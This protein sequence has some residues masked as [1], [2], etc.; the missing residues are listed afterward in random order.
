MGTVHVNPC[1]GLP[2]VLLAITASASAGGSTCIGDFDNNGIV[3]GADLG[4]LLSAWGTPAFDPSGDGNVD[5]TDLGIV[6]AAWGSCP[7]ALEWS[8]VTQLTSTSTI[9]L[10]P[11]GATVKTWT[12]GGQ[13]ASVAYLRPDGS[14]V[15]PCV[16]SAGSLNSA[17]RGGRIQIFS[18]AGTLQNDL[19]V[20]TSTSQQ[21]HDIRPMPNG[22]ILCVVWDVRSVAEQTAAGRINATASVWSEQILEL[23]PTGTN[24]YDI[25]WQWK[26]WDH[27][28]QD[29]A[30]GSANY[31]T[32]ASH[33]ELID[34][35]YSPAASPV[36][37]IHMNSIDY[38]A[39][40]DEIVVSSRSWSELWVI[41]HSTTTAQAASH[42]GGTRGRGGDL[43]Y[44]WGNPLASR[45]G[46]SADRNF[47]V[48]HSATWIPT[49][50]PGAGNIMVFNNG[51]R[52]G[53]TND[54]SQVVELAPPRDTSGGYVVPTTG[55]FGPAVPT[56]TV[57]S[58]GAFYGGPTQCGAFR[59]LSNTTLITL[60]SSDTLF[61]VDASGHTISTRTL[62]GSVAR[63]PRYRLVNGLWIGP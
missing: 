27:L 52:T 16:Y 1:A 38:N 44:R 10:D 35:N 49:G 4:L 40:R 29:V 21:H 42:T 12:G 41:D 63:V 22:N 30:P 2:I 7:V 51:D 31:T 23:K 18:P 61:E 37:W 9:A 24:T 43:L 11:T 54:W 15:R 6:L 25:V 50:M 62:T 28:A 57:G 36:D 56:W 55:A 53:N 5:G 13:G 45:R 14:L 47:Y 48:C 59:T 34:A 19:L 58:A 17:G 46:T 32:V 20:A 26:A 33:P 60:T 3:N 8:I 39:E